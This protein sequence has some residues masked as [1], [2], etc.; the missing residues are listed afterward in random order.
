[1]GVT[2][3]TTLGLTDEVLSAA[4]AALFAYPETLASFVKVLS[5]IF[6]EGRS[7]ACSPSP[8]FIDL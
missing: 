4:T 7:L 3:G 5:A 8:L 2:V 1:M 6:I